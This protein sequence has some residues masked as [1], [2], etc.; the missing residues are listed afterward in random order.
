MK[1]IFEELS[2]LKKSD[3]L[4]KKI[5]QEK[6]SKKNHLKKSEITKIINETKS[7]LSEEDSDK[8]IDYFCQKV[9][10]N[11]QLANNIEKEESELKK[12]ENEYDNYQNNLA[13]HLIKKEKM[14]KE[15]NEEEI[16]SQNED[17]KI[18]KR[19]FFFIFY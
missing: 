19:F 6:H 11:L 7:Q 2:N 13:E 12:L 18:I 9:E 16:R 10:E 3:S 5:I 4:F 8:L 17:E 15:E 14:P 1:K